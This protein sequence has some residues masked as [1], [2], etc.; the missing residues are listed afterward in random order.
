[1][2][3]LWICW[4]RLGES[5]NRFAFKLRYDAH[6]L[7]G[8]D[9]HAAAV[10]IAIAECHWQGWMIVGMFAVHNRSLFRVSAYHYGPN[11]GACLGTGSA[12]GP[13]APGFKL[14]MLALVSES[15][16]IHVA[17]DPCPVHLP[18]SCSTCS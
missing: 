14:G 13:L 7:S 4:R 12:P 3:R 18:L 15:W 1:V 8:V 9:F 16:G 10:A 5:F 11:D 6:S 2:L 17:R